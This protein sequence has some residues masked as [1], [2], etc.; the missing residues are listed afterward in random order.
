MTFKVSTSVRDKLLTSLP[1][2]EI[3]A[4]GYLDIY[5]GTV[6]STADASIGSATL[7]CRVSNNNSGVGLNFNLTASAGALAKLGSETWSG[8]NVAGGTAAFYRFVQSTDD[9]TLSTTQDRLQGAVSTSGAELNL[10]S[11]TLVLSALLTID[12]F[13]VTFPTS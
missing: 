13:T 4:L 10:V 11:V 9:G 6:P 2:R 5:A 8:S 1:L 3:F 7:L 12:S